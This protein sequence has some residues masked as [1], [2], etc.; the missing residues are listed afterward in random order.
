MG[1][2]E[3]GNPE[4]AARNLARTRRLRDA[5]LRK[6]WRTGRDLSYFEDEGASHNETAWAGRFGAV[7]RFLFS[8][9]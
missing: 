1:T 7:L 3:G 4:D 5:L 6:G 9:K 2:N 8:R